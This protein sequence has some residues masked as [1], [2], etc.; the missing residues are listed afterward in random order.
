MPNT[1][2][3]LVKDSLANPDDKELFD[4]AYSAVT[5]ESVPNMAYSELQKHPHF[6]EWKPQ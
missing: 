3:R 5:R 6:W 1:A 4:K 2:W